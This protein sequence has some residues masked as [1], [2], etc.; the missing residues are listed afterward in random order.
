MA[1][2]IKNLQKLLS[3]DHCTLLTFLRDKAESSKF[4]YAVAGDKLLK[5]WVYN[6]V[7]EHQESLVYCRVENEN[8]ESLRLLVVSCFYS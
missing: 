3:A 7:M 8:I 6:A 5:Y 1:D 2:K 4:A